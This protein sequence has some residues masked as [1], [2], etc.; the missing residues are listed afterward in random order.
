MPSNEPSLP[1]SGDLQ[2]TGAFAPDWTHP[3]AKVGAL[4]TTR[5]RARSAGH[6]SVVRHGDV[7]WQEKASAAPYADFNLGDHVGDDPAMVAA[8]RATLARTLGAHPVWLHQV[9]G[10]HVPRVTQADARASLTRPLTADGSWTTDPGVACTVMVADCLPVLL[11]A[12]G[13]RGVAALHAGWRGLSGTGGGMAGRGVLE[14]GVASL[15]EGAGCDPQDLQAWLGPCIGPRAFEVGADVLQGFGADPA[16]AHPR[17]MPITSRAASADGEAAPRKWWGDLAGLGADRLRG[18]GLTSIS[19]G[20]WC[21]VSDA[22]RFFS[23]RRDGITGRQAA[24]IWI[25]P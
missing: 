8:H 7:S 1:P 13:G 24:C 9:H 20:D 4:M 10:H 12:P 16:Q 21:T 11:A 23:F 17:F 3:V 6:A 5:R 18:L 2:R 22:S 15:C 14:V 19:G 25:L